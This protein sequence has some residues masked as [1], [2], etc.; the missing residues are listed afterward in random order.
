MAG[1]KN[2]DFHILPPSPWPLMGSIAALIFA[3]G[4]IMWMH[5][6]AFGSWV[7]F[8]GLLGLFATFFF[9]WGS[10]VLSLIHI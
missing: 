6:M 2:H 4:A 5:E 1:A 8:V 9:W 10:V 3:V 7:F